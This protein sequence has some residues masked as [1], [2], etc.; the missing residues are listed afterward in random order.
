MELREW[1]S[2]GDI[3]KG[4][5]YCKNKLINILGTLIKSSRVINIFRALSGISTT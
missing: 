3:L 2:V 4:V 5:N 1:R